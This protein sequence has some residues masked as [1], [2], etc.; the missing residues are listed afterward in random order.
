M[1]VEIGSATLLLGDC[2]EL[3]PGEVPQCEVLVT[4][5][6]YG[7]AFRSN[8]RMVRHAAIAND[9]SADHL[10]WACAQAASHS[11][12]IFCRWDNLPAVPP[13]RSLITWVKNGHSMGDLAHEHARATEAVLFYPGPCHAFPRGRPTDVVHAPRTGNESHPTEKPAQLMATILTW[14]AGVVVDPFMGSGTT[15]VACMQQGRPFVGIEIDPRH[16]DTACKRID[17][18]WSQRALFDPLPDL[19]APEQRALI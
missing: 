6:P 17:A 11:K 12:Y 9:E 10:I 3:F 15:G 19:Q 5:P 2:L 1:R 18:A 16:F 7:M 8:M 13:P 4:D 14:T